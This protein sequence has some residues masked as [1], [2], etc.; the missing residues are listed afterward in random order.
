MHQPINHSHVQLQSNHHNYQQQRLCLSGCPLV[1]PS[2][3]SGSVDAFSQIHSLAR[4]QL[5]P[6]AHQLANSVSQVTTHRDQPQQQEQHPQPHHKTNN[7]HLIHHPR[8]HLSSVVLQNTS[9]LMGMHQEHS[10]PPES[11]ISQHSSSSEPYSAKLGT[12]IPL[13]ILYFS[14]F[15][16][17][18][19]LKLV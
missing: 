6:P 1:S 13:G 3:A 11:L 2:S 8:R 7:R 5:P 4:H 17:S 18:G 15:Y 12:S 9:S 19:S 10:Q 16:S 14:S